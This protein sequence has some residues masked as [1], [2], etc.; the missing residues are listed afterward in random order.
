MQKY[1][2][3]YFSDQS[4]NYSQYLLKNCLLLASSM[5]SLSMV[6]FALPVGAN[7][8]SQ[9]STSSEN[10]INSELKKTPK[11]ERYIASVDDFSTFSTQAQDLLGQ[12]NTQPTLEIPSNESNDLENEDN[13]PAFESELEPI[14][15]ENEVQTEAAP[16]N[17][18]RQKLTG[19]WGGSRTKMGN[20]GITLDLEFTQFYQGLASG[21]GSKTFE[22]GGRLDSLVNFNFE[23]M[24]LWK[25]GGFHSHLE[26]RYGDLPGSIGGAF[27]P[28][29]S[30]MEFPGDSPDTLVA[31]SLYFSQKF[32]DQVS[33]LIGKINALDLLQ[34]NSFFGG[35]GNHRF[36]NTV[37]V[38][39]PSGLVPPVFFGAIA[40][41]NLDPVTVSLWVY[42]PDDRTK[43]YWP[44]YLFGNGITFYLTSSYNTKIAGRSTVFSLNG[45]YT[46]KNGTDF[47]SVADSFR[48]DLEPLTKSG[49]YSVGFEF[50]HFLYQN[51]D[52]PANKWGVFLK[53]SFSDGNPNYVQN[54]IY[55]GIGGQGLFR[56]RELDSFGL[57]YFYYNLSDDLQDSLDD[58]ARFVSFGDTSGFEVYYSYAVTPWFYLTTDVQ[59]VW[60]PRSTFDN[61]L[62]FGVRANIR[63]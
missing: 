53:G 19:D 57:G 48:N 20:A 29:N 54:A 47:S 62:I 10:S 1:N 61:A 42:D 26:Y 52:N 12:N 32:G 17:P 37:F 8:R 9:L 49:S 60:T 5:L 45:I 59:Y 44:E 22:Y 38:A 15:P 11:S 13:I 55:G 58:L 27:F 2:N 16:P 4:P 21:T 46:T 18:Y 3:Y 56:G 7:E 30:G 34:T 6:S 23:K 43:E 36:Q 40:S 14:T 39:P 28:T 63:F 51:P 35:W 31:T 25:G 24:G 33:L 41:V 50:S